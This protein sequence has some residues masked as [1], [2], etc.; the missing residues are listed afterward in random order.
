MISS[1]FAKRRARRFDSNF[2][3]VERT[4]AAPVTNGGNEQEAA[5]AKSMRNPDAAFTVAARR[6]TLS[7]SADN[8]GDDRPCMVKS[9]TRY[10]SSFI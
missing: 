2:E 3:A 5:F 6:F 7:A 4:F 10:I 9:G 8:S 1:E